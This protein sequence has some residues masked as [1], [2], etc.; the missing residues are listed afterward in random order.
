[1]E[2]IFF[3][4]IILGLW[5]GFVGFTVLWIVKRV[6]PGIVKEMNEQGLNE[7]QQKMVLNKAVFPPKFHK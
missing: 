2:W 1:M 6:I 5:F 3:Y 4:L 7:I